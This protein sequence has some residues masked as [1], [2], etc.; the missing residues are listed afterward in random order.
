MMGE[1]KELYN[2]SK[3]ENINSSSSVFYF[4]AYVPQELIHSA[5][6][7]P[8]RFI[9]TPTYFERTDEYL[10]KYLCPYLRATT[11]EILRREIKIPRA[12]FTDACDSSKR[13]YEVWK[14]LNM[15]E[16]IF[17]LQVPFGEE[18][19]DILYFS[20]QLK[21]LFFSLNENGKIEDIERSI[22]LYNL[23]RKKAQNMPFSHILFHSM[24]INDFLNI[25]WEWKENKPKFY[26]YSTMY[27]LELIEYIHDMDINIVFDDSCFGIRTLEE[28]KPVSKDPFYNLAYYYMKREGCVRRR[29]LKD[30]VS[31]IKERILKEKVKGVIFY[32]LKFCDPILFY[33]PLLVREL[34]KEG[35]PT[36]LLEDDYTLG[37]KEQ[38]RTRLEAFLEMVL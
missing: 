13:I 3:I 6:Y 10:P 27:P 21:R 24:N 20:E 9:P 19:E 11:E 38:I 35:I 22:D 14:F 18:E 37:I 31:Q 12:I 32:S 29:N 33:I 16:E 26:L 8:F 2:E 1:I 17:F 4:C 7:N 15:A 5:G 25:S 34:K 23:G 36:L 30:K 28:I